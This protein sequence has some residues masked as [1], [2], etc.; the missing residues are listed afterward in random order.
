M[1]ATV[2]LGSVEICIVIILI[3]SIFGSSGRRPGR[4]QYHRHGY[5]G[6]DSY[7]F[8]FISFSKVNPQSRHE[9]RDESGHVR[10]YY[11]YKD[12]YGLIKYVQYMASPETGFRITRS[13]LFD[14]NT[15]NLVHQVNNRVTRLKRK[16][17]GPV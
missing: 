11:S 15:G 2:I 1:K 14:P 17:K 16:R 4:I 9:E 10:G 5:N 12:P 3:V 13:C 7:E 8:G 6:G